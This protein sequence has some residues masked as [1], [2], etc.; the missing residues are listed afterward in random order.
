[1]SGRASGGEVSR[2]GT[3]CRG[4]VKSVGR[5]KSEATS[6]NTIY[7]SALRMVGSLRFAHPGSNDANQFT[8]L[9]TTTSISFAPG[10]LK[11]DD[12]TDFNC[13]G[14]VTFVA[15]SPSDFAT[16]VKSTGGSMKSMPT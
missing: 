6:G 3:R 13:E 14:S 10:R 1:M 15:S 9:L 12:K 4:G 11:A 5:A 16:P 8:E 7:H 2:E